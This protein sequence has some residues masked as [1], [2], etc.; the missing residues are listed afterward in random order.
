MGLNYKYDTLNAR[1]QLEFMQ[2][3]EVIE[4]SDA[5]TSR[6]VR[7][8]YDQKLMSLKKALRHFENVE[9]KATVTYTGIEEKL[10]LKATVTIECADE[11]LK[12][13]LETVTQRYNAIFIPA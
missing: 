3:I 4:V 12:K 7:S 13:I 5:I 1:Y 2:Y 10:A 9:T 6:G 11:S 8:I